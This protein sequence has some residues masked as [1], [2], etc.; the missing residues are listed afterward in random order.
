MGIYCWKHCYVLIVVFNSL[1]REKLETKVSL[2]LMATKGLLVCP[3][4]LDLPD[5]GEH[6]EPRDPSVTRAHL[7]P[8]VSE[9]HPDPRDPL[10][11]RENLEIEDS[12]D[13]LDHL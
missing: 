1:H 4:L 5:L 12:L 8:K 13:Q 11:I 6:K 2:E 10:E 3:E 9:D 7:V